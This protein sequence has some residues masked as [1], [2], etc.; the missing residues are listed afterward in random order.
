MKKS[1]LLVILLAFHLSSHAFDWKS[2]S[3]DALRA[4]TI[5]F[6]EQFK[7]NTRD[8]KLAEELDAFVAQRK[9]E[10][11]P[12]AWISATNAFVDRWLRRY[13]AEL[14]KGGDCSYERRSLLLLRDY[15]M[16][17]DN[18]REDATQQVKD[19]YEASIL[20]MH[21]DAETEALKW[22]SRKSRSSAL[23]V[24]KVYNMGFFIRSAGQVVGI[25]LQWEG[26]E[27]EMRMIASKIDVLF[28]SHPHDDHYSIGLI[29]AVLDAG[30]PV[31][32]SED[33]VPDYTGE[34]KVIVDKDNLEGKTVNGISFYSCMGNQGPKVPNNV[35]VIKVGDWNIAQNGDNAVP[36]AESFLAG[37]RVDVL[38]TACWN[39][40]KRTMDYVRSNSEGTSC[41]YIPAHENEWLHTVDHREA[42][43]ELFT[44]KDRF[45][46]PEYDY[47]PSVIMDAA[48]DAFVFRK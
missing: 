34:S 38:I 23:E 27:D 5:T 24:C 30:K 7:A 1:V 48:G 46:D 29:K 39:G 43:C 2:R 32:M 15:P 16:H 12:C 19:S 25:D 31:V 11:D 8:V 41:I 45:G 26:S 44:R 21:R 17:V 10:T 14:S 35:M 37:H 9:A 6:A 47:F 18:Y 28:V 20:K 13:P 36:E 42:Y 22:L 33:I 3:N 40:F 4:E